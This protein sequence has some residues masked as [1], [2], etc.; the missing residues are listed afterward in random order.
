MVCWAASGIGHIR[1]TKAAVIAQQFGAFGV[2]TAEA[3]H[4]VFGNEDVQQGIAV[5]IQ[6]RGAAGPEAKW[7]RAASF[8]N[9]LELSVDVFKKKQTLAVVPL[10]FAVGHVRHIE[11]VVAVVIKVSEIGTGGT[12]VD[13]QTLLAVQHKLVAFVGKQHALPA[14]GHDTA[15]AFIPRVEHT[16]VKVNQSVAVVIAPT[17][18]VALDAADGGHETEF[19]CFVAE[20]EGVG[21]L[22]SACVSRRIV[23]NVKFIVCKCGS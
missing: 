7:R 11:F 12:Q 2:R 13:V 5:I 19:F 1:K 10:L 8:R 16:G 18:T 17:R 23:G 21:S 6:K 15:C 9:I 3:H 4:R 20:G 22:C 14:V